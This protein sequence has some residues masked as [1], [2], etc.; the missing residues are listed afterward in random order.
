MENYNNL[1]YQD[2]QELSITDRILTGF[3]IYLMDINQIVTSI[4]RE[5]MTQ[6]LKIGSLNSQLLIF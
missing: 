6:A 2:E 4:Q 3:D 1:L 5:K